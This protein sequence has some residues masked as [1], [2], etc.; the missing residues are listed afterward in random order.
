[1][2]AQDLAVSLSGAILL[3]YLLIAAFFWRFWVRARERLFL[4]FTAAFCLLAFERVLLL[5]VGWIEGADRPLIYLTR[6]LAFLVI[7]AG[8]WDANRRPPGE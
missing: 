1:M 3:G 8:I 2:N 6:L 5:I 7:I 4:F